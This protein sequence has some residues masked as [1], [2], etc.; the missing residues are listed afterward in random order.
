ME[1]LTK[2]S[3]IKL[4]I[5]S[6]LLGCVTLLS[7]CGDAP[8]NRA[9]V[10]FLLIDAP[11]D[12]D[13]VWIEIRGVEILPQGTRGAENANWIF[14]P[15]TPANKMVNVSEQVGENRL[16]LGRKEIH[17][18]AIS[19]IRLLIGD[20]YYLL[21]NGARIPLNPVAGIED[22][23]EMDVAF[24]V[25]VGLAF[26]IYIDFNLASSIIND[27]QGG[28]NLKPALRAFTVAQTATIRGTVLPNVA[29]PHIFA[30]SEKDTFGTLTGPNGLFL[31]R[32]LPPGPYQL[33]F[34]A[35]PPY[36]DTAFMVNTLPDT[37]S[38]LPNFNLRMNEADSE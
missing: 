25:P 8:D 32:G 30:I 21:K 36:L 3:R 37:V 33:R 31:L 1:A 26:D 4:L 2:I 20:E 15:Y 7:Y 35:R 27:G 10:N 14:F 18:G 24:N 12:F 6:I 5:P 29:R 9:L 17:A 34:A 16:L 23:L 13:Q 22:Y 38:Q 19:K 11:G 28:F